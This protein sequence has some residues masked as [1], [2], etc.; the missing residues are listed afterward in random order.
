[1]SMIAQEKFNTDELSIILSDCSE[2]FTV[3]FNDNTCKYFCEREAKVNEVKT[4]ST[5]YDEL[6]SSCT[7]II[8]T[9]DPAYQN[10][11][12][13]KAGNACSTEMSHN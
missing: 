8:M 1:M 9:S 3:V 7:S 5:F 12:K 4:C 2:K 11:M 6:P 13:L 10:V